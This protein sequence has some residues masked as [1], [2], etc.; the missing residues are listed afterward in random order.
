MD[1]HCKYKDPRQEPRAEG[2][3]I[4]IIFIVNKSNSN[5]SPAHVFTAITIIIYNDG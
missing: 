3:D 1:R 2:H 4:V 5:I